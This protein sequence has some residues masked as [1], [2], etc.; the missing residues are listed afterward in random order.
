MGATVSPAQEA[1]PFLEFCL[2]G[3]RSVAP[4]LTPA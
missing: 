1:P 2:C 4:S 3:S